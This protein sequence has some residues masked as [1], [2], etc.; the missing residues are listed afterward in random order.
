MIFK[1]QY[2]FV[3][4]STTKAPIFMKLEIFIHKI[5]KNHQKIFRK[6][7]CTHARTQGADVCMDLYEKSFDNSLLSYEWKSQIS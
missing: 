2:W 7:L 1:S 6:D 5:E 3:N 4:I